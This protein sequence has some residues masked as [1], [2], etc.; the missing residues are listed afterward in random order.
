MKGTILNYRGSHKQQNPR[1]MLV[2]VEGV[3]NKEAAAKLKG[4]KAVWT[5]PSGKKIIGIL[6][7]PHGNKGVVRVHFREK[8]LPGQ[9]L[10]TEVEI[11]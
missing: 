9:A 5:S 6:A 4:K 11:E 3:D 8:G 7:K 2:R 1:Q 10:G